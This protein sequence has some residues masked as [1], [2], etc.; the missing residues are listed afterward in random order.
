MTIDGEV[1]QLRLKA[2]RNASFRGSIGN[3]K[4]TEYWW[5][6][7]VMVVGSR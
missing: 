6:L 7:V 3:T 5:R 2:I 4:A 1:V